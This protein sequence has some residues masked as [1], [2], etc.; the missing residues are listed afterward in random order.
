MRSKKKPNQELR[1]NSPSVIDWSP[2][3]SCVR[4]APR[5][6]SVSADS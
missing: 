1:P 2:A 6:A 3:S 5:I 4:T